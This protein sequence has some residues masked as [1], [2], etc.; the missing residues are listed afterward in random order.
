MR[1]E[2]EL[3][4]EDA[5]TIKFVVFGGILGDHPPQDRAKEFRES[6]FKQIR[7]LGK[8]QMTTDTAVLV[9]CEIMELGM[10]IGSMSFLK[11]PEVP[12]DSNVMP[13]LDT[14]FNL[15]KLSDDSND[16][17]K[18]KSLSDYENSDLYKEHS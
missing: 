15:E 13:F 9:S 18:L 2:K 3:C 17:F 6:N 4:H 12:T 11:D 5:K 10:S 14:N 1:A 16:L 7:N 8:T